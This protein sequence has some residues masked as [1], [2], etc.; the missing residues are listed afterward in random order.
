[1]FV[2]LGMG[3]FG[4]RRGG[5]GSEGVGSGGERRGGNMPPM[6][7]HSRPKTKAVIRK[8]A[9]IRDSCLVI[10]ENLLVGLGVALLGVAAGTGK[11]VFRER[12]AGHVQGREIYGRIAR[13]PGL[14]TFF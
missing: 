4:V 11:T 3:S 14:A 2:C 7:L 1:M 12:R 10:R 13:P 6:P 5:T 8:K 9:V